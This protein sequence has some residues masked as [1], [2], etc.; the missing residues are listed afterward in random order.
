MAG[1]AFF[2]FK[3]IKRSFEMQTMHYVTCNIIFDYKISDLF[4]MT[5]MSAF[6]PPGSPSKM[7]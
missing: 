4:L 2:D 7:V 6:S 3:E 1:S 5:P